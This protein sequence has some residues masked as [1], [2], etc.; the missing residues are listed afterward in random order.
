MLKYQYDHDEW[1]YD[2]PKT[3]KAGKLK[4]P[5]IPDVLPFAGVRT[6][7]HISATSQHVFYTYKV[8]ATGWEPQVGICESLAEY[9]V[10]EQCLVSPDIY[11]L[12]TQPVQVKYRH[13]GVA[14]NHTFDVRL[15]FANGYR[16][17]IFV[18]NRKS[19]LKPRTQGE[20]DSILK[21]TTREHANDVV[22]V[23]ADQY[24]RAHRE[25]LSRMR[26]AVEHPDPLSDEAV[27]RVF[28]SARNII[29]VKDIYPHTEFSKPRVFDSCNRLIA[30]GEL[31]ANLS[32]VF[33]KH[34]RIWRRK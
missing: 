20:I 26:L 1:C 5:S 32:N 15:T 3:K 7:S 18:R 33:S 30:C 31:C 19:L 12:E 25:N 28:D 22:I 4:I 34:S 29:W 14:R 24:A 8:P 9:A 13:E 11:N 17:L 16:R 2:E 6:P 27:L 21:A 23:E 10:C